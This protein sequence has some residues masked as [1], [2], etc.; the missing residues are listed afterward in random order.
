[1]SLIN[2]IYQSKIEELNQCF[3]ETEKKVKQL[4]LY[5]LELSIPSINQLRYVSHHL[6][7]ASD[8]NNLSVDIV[9]EE[10]KKAL[11]HC[12]RAKFDAIEIWITH[13][14]GEIKKFEEQYSS[15][16]ETQDVITNYVGYLTDA[17]NTV[18]ALNI[19]SDEEKDR[20]E[21]YDN[22]IPHY[23]KLQKIVNEFKNS[24]P[25]IAT[26]I[27]DNNKEK[28]RVRRHFT[29]NVI[30]GILGIIIAS[31]V[32]ANKIGYFDNNQNQSKNSPIINS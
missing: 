3:K 20:K 6:L 13:L 30:I 17:Q 25:L 26:L 24:K 1:M 18:D 10:I 14:L 16:K 7:K 21:Y 23:E 8:I 31:A 28:N 4:E 2:S 12:Q 29:I 15:I 9:Q 19:I 32:L 11:H 27:E 5:T 22:I